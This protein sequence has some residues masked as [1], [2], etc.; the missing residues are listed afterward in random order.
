LSVKDGFCAVPELFLSAW[1]DRRH[2]RQVDPTRCF[3]LPHARKVLPTTYFD[4]QFA[5][6]CGG[7]GTNGVSAG[8]NVHPTALT[9]G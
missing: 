2:A 5:A 9:P 4:S 1:I 3:R 6:N 7:S 8:A